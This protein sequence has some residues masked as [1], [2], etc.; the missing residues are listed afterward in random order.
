VDTLLAVHQHDADLVG[1]EGP[2]DGRLETGEDQAEA[3]PR[4]AANRRTVIGK[5]DPPVEGR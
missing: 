4:G 3:A 2:T 1:R 5:I